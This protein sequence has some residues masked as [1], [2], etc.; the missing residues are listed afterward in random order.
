[1]IKSAHTDTSFTVSEDERGESPRSP[2]P[3][4]LSPQNM[5][6]EAARALSSAVRSPLRAPLDLGPN[7]LPRQ[8]PCQRAGAPAWRTPS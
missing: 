6:G 1:M 3:K 5:L 7:Q 8:R 4:T 2:N